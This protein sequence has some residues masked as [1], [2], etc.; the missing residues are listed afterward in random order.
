MCSK[1]S[2]VGETRFIQ[3]KKANKTP[4]L[5][6]SPSICFCFF[7]GCKTK[8]KNML[9][10][11]QNISKNCCCETLS[12]TFVFYGGPEVQ[13]ASTNHSTQKYFKDHNK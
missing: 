4:I 1:K 9:C 11:Y 10:N 6:S 13:I 3:H 12:P 8:D 2:V 7:W 5:F